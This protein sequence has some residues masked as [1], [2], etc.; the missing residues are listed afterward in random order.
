M[1]SYSIVVARYNEDIAW[2]KPLMDHCVIY[3]KGPAL[4]LKNEISLPNVGRESHTYLYHIIQNYDSLTDIVV[5]TQA[6][7]SDHR[8]SNDP[9]YLLKMRDEAEKAGKSVPPEIH[10]DGRG[11]AY[12]WNSSFN[13]DKRCY[14]SIFGN[15]SCY[16]EKRIVPFKTWFEN[17]I[18]TPYPNPISIYPNALFAVTKKHILSRP[19]SYYESLIQQC[20]YAIKPT[21]AHF[22]ERSWYYIFDGSQ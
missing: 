13:L 2:L 19:K 14:L 15:P 17:H 21:E 8:G 5:F 3:N 12:C 18:T 11:L 16:K 22:F 20:D 6:R 4:G 7:I 10:T 9:N 1:A